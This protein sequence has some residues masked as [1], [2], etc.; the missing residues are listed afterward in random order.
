MFSIAVDF[1]HLYL[2]QIAERWTRSL[3]F[4]CRKHSNRHRNYCTPLSRTSISNI[5]CRRPWWILWCM[6]VS[7]IT[8]LPVVLT[9]LFNRYLFVD[10]AGIWILP[11]W[12]RLWKIL[13]EIFYF[14]GIL[15]SSKRK[16]SI[17]GTFLP[18]WG[19]IDKSSYR[20]GVDYSDRW[21]PL[22]IL[23]HENH[24]EKFPIANVYVIHEFCIS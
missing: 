19:R 24:K 3:L 7:T 14:G 10:F 1:L 16:S 20:F 12:V 4:N 2:W 9:F 22:S 6:S 15:I 18:F 21:T 23:L 5:L 8:Q 17:L 13:E 11:L